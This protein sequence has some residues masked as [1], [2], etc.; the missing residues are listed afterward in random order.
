MP[1]FAL[2]LFI[3]ES[4]FLALLKLIQKKIRYR[5]LGVITDCVIS[6]LAKSGHYRPRFLVVDEDTH[7]EDKNKADNVDNDVRSLHKV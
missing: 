1:F 2:S 7:Y 6:F 5:L 4:P 3:S